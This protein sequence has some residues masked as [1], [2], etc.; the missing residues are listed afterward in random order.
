[1]PV[2]SQC[3][4]DYFFSRLNP[5]ETEAKFQLVEKAYCQSVDQIRLKRKLDHREAGQ[6]FAAMIDLHLR[7]KAHKNETGKEGIDAYNQRSRIFLSEILLTG[8]NGTVT[9]KEILE[10]I[11]NH[12]SLQ[13]VSSPHPSEFLTSDHPSVWTALRPA[14]HS[15]PRLHMITLP[16][17]PN[18]AAVAFDKRVIQVDG[19]K[20]DHNDMQT[21]N[22]GQIQN[23]RRCVYASS[24][25]AIDHL[26]I[27]RNHFSNKKDS[28]SV[29]RENSWRLGLQYLPIEHHFSFIKLRPPLL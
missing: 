5:A 10:H 7:N 25:L 24:Q 27:L 9:K 3:A 15:R 22:S 16:L 4:E 28:S 20:A 1:V 12:W 21:F 14:M 17:A 2:V 13:I 18:L 6:L 8:R 23:A 29:V 26:D 19:D 11:L